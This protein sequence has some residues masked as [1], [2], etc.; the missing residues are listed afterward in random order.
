MFMWLILWMQMAFVWAEDIVL[1]TQYTGQF[2]VQTEGQGY[3]AVIFVPGQEDS[4]EDFFPVVERTQSAKMRTVVW[5]MPGKGTRATEEMIAPFLHL[6]ITAIIQYLQAQGVRDIQC[7]G[8][9]LGGILCMQAI[10][11]STP[12]SQIAMITP[13]T[14]ELRQNLFTNIDNYP[15]TDILVMVAFPDV[16]TE[17]TIDRLQKHRRVLMRYS[18]GRFQ[19]ALMLVED[20]DMVSYLVEWIYKKNP[21]REKTHTIFPKR[22]NMN[23]PTPQNNEGE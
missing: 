18:T 1:Q 14:T 17:V 13:V 23:T 19:H 22:K 3:R 15:N 5:E 7:V 2:T 12:L 21:D 8:A 16:V 20:P 9:G 10:S 6:E 4:K 11:E